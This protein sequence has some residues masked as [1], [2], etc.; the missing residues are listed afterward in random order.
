M[1]LHYLSLAWQQL[2]KYRLQSFVS[3][4]SLGIGFACFA[5]ASMWIKYE[6]TYDASFKDADNLYVILQD[7]STTLYP[8]IDVRTLR[9][10]PQLEHLS[11]VQIVQSDSINGQPMFFSINNGKISSFGQGWVMNDTNFVELFGLDIIEG[12]SSFV[13]N[14]RE[15][16]ISDQLARHL[17]PDESP[18]GKELQTSSKGVNGTSI[19]RSHRIAAVFRYWGDHSNF[20]YIYYLCRNSA[21]FSDTHSAAVFAHISPRVDLEALNAHLDT[22]PL[23]R[24]DMSVYR[25]IDAAE[26]KKAFSYQRQEA[27]PITKVRY[28]T[29]QYEKYAQ[30]KINHIYLF[31]IA[32]GMLIAC[33]LLNYLTIFVN[34]LFIRRREMALRTVFGA[35]GKDLMVQ[36]LTEYGLLLVIALLVGLFIISG[37]MEQFL[38]MTGLPQIESYFYGESLIYVSLVFVVSM[39]VS[40]PAIWYFRRQSLQSNISTVGALVHYNIFRRIST[41]AQIGI[42]IFCIFCSAVLL[43]QL[44]TLRHGDI[45]FERENRMTYSVNYSMEAVRE[46]LLFFL[47]QCPEIDTAIACHQPIYPIFGSFMQRLSPDQHPELNRVIDVY[48]QYIS[49][50]LVDFYNPTLLQGRW[51]RDGEKNACM[52]NETL[53]HQ[54]GWNNPLEKSVWGKQIVGVV[55]DFHNESPII[56]SKNYLLECEP[57]YTPSNFLIRYKPGMRQALMSKIETFFKERELTYAPHQWRDAMEEYSCLLVSE[58]KLKQ[59]LNITTCVCILIALFG[60]WSMIM[61]TCEQRRK[62]IAVRKVFGATTKDILDMFFLEY[63]VLQ[64]VAALVAFPVGYA[65]M[66]PWLEQYVVQTAI[67]WWIYVGIFM[68]VALLVALCVGWRVW[69]TATFVLY[70]SVTLQV[71]RLSLLTTHIWRSLR[72]SG[73]CLCSTCLIL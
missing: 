62:E 30:M 64:G 63:M 59:L 15:I 34:R 61:L 20:P 39:L 24:R 45:G 46:E 10:L 58:N 47:N 18:I 35:T 60:V 67:P 37:F 32:G 27:V 25:G 43:K 53:A 54:M 65:C 11:H 71:L 23:Y 56:K 17:W 31:A 19:K 3:I 51:L 7:K 52:V 22:M 41:G 72:R 1:L 12:S 13:H 73:T 57:E 2:E 49:G 69:K 33:G 28:A 42:S 4:V 26:L 14:E 5:L 6:T 16:A 29:E 66:K 68:A 36:F 21:E 50:A 9:E 70:F 38:T 55:K 48:T 8:D 44:D 40:L